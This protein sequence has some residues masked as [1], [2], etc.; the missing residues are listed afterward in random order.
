MLSFV[1]QSQ[2]G[3]TISGSTNPARSQISLVLALM[4]GRKENM[5]LKPDKVFG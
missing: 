5:M 2:K 3:R 4:I 1:D